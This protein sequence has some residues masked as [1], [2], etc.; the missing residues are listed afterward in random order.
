MMVWYSSNPADCLGESMRI[1][2]MPRGF[3]LMIPPLGVGGNDDTACGGDGSVSRDE[4][5]EVG[6]ESSDTSRKGEMAV[7]MADLRSIICAADRKVVESADAIEAL[8]PHNPRI[9]ISAEHLIRGCF[10]IVRS[11]IL[12]PLAVLVGSPD[13]D[14]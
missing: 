11:G 10:I 12:S 9:D 7:A 4:E 3:G 13:A 14:L 1:V 2:V 5:V 6:A 8:N